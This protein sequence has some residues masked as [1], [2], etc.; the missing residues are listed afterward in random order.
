[1][2]VR[3]YQQ[4]VAINP[5]PNPHAHPCIGNPSRPEPA[6]EQGDPVRQVGK[7]RRGGLDGLEDPHELHHGG[8]PLAVV[9]HG[10]SLLGGLVGM[11]GGV[12]RRCQR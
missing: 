10:C 3:A 8:V 11:G 4:R 9:A 1:M 5:A 12:A 7:G 6:L 2:C